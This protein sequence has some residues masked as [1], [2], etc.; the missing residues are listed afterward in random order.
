[1][2]VNLL[3][4]TE[5]VAEVEIVPC[6]LARLFGAR[7]RVVALEWRAYSTHRDGEAWHAVGSRRPLGDLYHA[8]MI[9]DALDCAVG[10]PAARA[11][12][13]H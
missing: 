1:M 5:T 11:R 8:A 4:R 6:W 9:R 12:V 10:L 7:R 2:R 13:A 3:Y